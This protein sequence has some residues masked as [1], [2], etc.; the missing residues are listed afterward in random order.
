LLH[1]TMLAA[2]EWAF[3]CLE[4]KW[5]INKNF[6]RIRLEYFVLTQHHYWPAAPKL[7]IR[8]FGKYL[9]I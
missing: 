5:E 3:S 7:E 9:P 6:T 8:V 2:V 1:I 4:A